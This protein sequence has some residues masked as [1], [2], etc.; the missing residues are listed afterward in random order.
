MEAN[1]NKSHAEKVVIT[2]STE[3]SVITDQELLRPEEAVGITVGACGLMAVV[4]VVVAGALKK[5]TVVPRNLGNPGDLESG[6]SGF[7]NSSAGSASGSRHG[8]VESGVQFGDEPSLTN[9]IPITILVYQL[10]TKK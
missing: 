3:I 5:T 1:H 4:M 8:V 9:P 6:G 7:S 10:V 2:N